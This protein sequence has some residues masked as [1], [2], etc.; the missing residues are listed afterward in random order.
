MY[1][2][3]FVSSDKARITAPKISTVDFDKQM[4]A[5]TAFGVDLFKAAA[6]T[7]A[8]NLFFS[9]HSISQAMAMLHAGARTVSEAEI[10]KVMHFDLA[11][12]RLHP[13]INSLDL[14]LASRGKG[15]KAADGKAFRLNVVNA[16]WGQQNYTF[17]TPYLDTLAVNY[18]AG[19]RLLDFRGA[20][21]VS[22]Q[23]INTW[24][25]KRTEG[26]IKDLIPPPSIT[27]NTK[28]VLTNAIYF[29][30][31]W[32]HAFDVKN[33][34]Q[35]PFVLGDGTSVKVPMMHGEVKTAR[36]HRE[37][38]LTAVALPYDCD[39]LSISGWV[40]DQKWNATLASTFTPLT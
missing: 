12:S 20:P 18:G 28:L 14:A 22:R 32:Q 30:A 9:P 33:T 4:A 19:L 37:S 29:N 5:S 36:Y 15:N 23:T 34:S 40:P 10:A 7:T 25:E 26:R 38:G 16:V 11:Q 39:E 13:V 35:R 1:A 3:D 21:Q 8:G 27:S 31:A 6:A 24:V 17:Q 2:G